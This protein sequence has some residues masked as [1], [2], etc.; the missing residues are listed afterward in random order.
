MPCGISLQSLHRIR[1]GLIL[2]KRLVKPLS[3]HLLNRIIQRRIIPSL[4]GTIHI[5]YFLETIRPVP[6]G[7]PHRLLSR[8]I[9]PCLLD[10]GFHFDRLIHIQ[11]FILHR[12]PVSQ[13]D[14]ILNVGIRFRRE[15]L[16]IILRFLLR[17]Q[18][19]QNLIHHHVGKSVG[20]PPTVPVLTVHFIKDGHL[21]RFVNQYRLHQLVKRL[22]Q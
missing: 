19:T 11:K 12:H 9:I 10:A 5:Q 8:I 6:S 3:R 22:R 17:I 13:I 20:K 16:Q 15:R 2:Y 1:K 4:P 14:L 7:Q 21:G 18:F